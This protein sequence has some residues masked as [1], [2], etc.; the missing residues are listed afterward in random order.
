M[1]L[2]EGE[3][4]DGR[5]ELVR[6]IGS[7]GMA[8]V[9]EARD[10]EL[11]R[12]VALKV[13]HDSFSR[14]AE[15][16]ARFRREASA[17]AGLQ[18][19]N[20]VGIYDRGDVDETY[21]IAME[22]IEGASLRDLIEGGLSVD[23]SAEIARQVLTAAAFA[24]E[25]GIVHR[26]LK[27]MN[28]LIDRAGRVRVADFGIARAGASEITRTGS[29]M[30]TA[31]YLS[32]EQAQGQEVGPPGDIYSIGVMLFEMLTGTVPFDGDNVVAVAMKQVSEQPVAPSTLNPAVSPALDAVV[33]KA[34]AK[35]P[36]NRFGTADEMREAIDAAISDPNASH[37]ERFAAMAAAAPPIGGDDNRRRNLWIAALLAVVAAL[38]LGGWLLSRG[39]DEARVPAV[40][41]ETEAR[42]TLALQEAGFEVDVDPIVSPV[43]EGLVIEQDPKGGTEVDEGSTVTIDVS[44]G[45]EPVAVPMVEGI[46]QKRAERKLEKA[47]LEFEVERE[48]SEEVEQGNAIGTSPAAGAEVDPDSVVTLLISSGVDL[49]E[50]PSVVGMNRIDAAATLRDAGFVVNQDSEDADAPEDEVIR[51]LPQAGSELADGSRVTIVYSTGDGSIQLDDFVGQ[52]ADFAERQLSGQGL[53]VRIRTEDVTNSSDDGVVLDQSPSGGSRVSSGDRVTLVVGEF[54]EPDPPPG[55][56]SG[57]GGG[58][59]SADSG[60]GTG[61]GSAS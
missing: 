28:V 61:S 37:T 17:A 42:A 40:K 57:S 3:R 56:G 38:I 14:D 43:R 23:D 53:N 55:G 32:P 39:D 19:P 13:M 47:G 25:R 12:Q 27:P 26:D 15:F 16:V 11:D 60:A 5:Y 52:D 54:V 58:D 4:L 1:R 24:H 34:L 18:H 41:G 45:P 6:R 49:A 46:P 51:Q 20:V 48:I 44:L 33:L 22:L 50:V 36:V 30:G 29:V 21:Y 9:W 8:D 35:D 7:G 2:T 59:G 31:Q 10:A